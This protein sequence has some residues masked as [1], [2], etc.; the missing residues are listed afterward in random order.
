MRHVSRIRMMASGWTTAILMAGLTFASTAE[1]TT[2]YSFGGFTLAPSTTTANTTASNFSFT[3]AFGVTQCWAFAYPDVACGGFGSAIGEFT[4]A[5]LA[6]YRLAI[7]GLSFDERNAGGAG[8]TAFH[9][10]TSADGFTSPIIS[11]ALAQGAPVFTNHAVSLSL[12]NLADPFVVRIAATGRDGLPMSSWF[13]DNVTL[14]VEAV[15]I[16]TAVPEP[17]TL[18]LLGTGIGFVTTRRRRRSTV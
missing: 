1:A 3:S 4:V 2:I 8:P 11:G 14:N 6:G 5:P 13:L 9:V 15:P 17:T 16:A 10:L 18:L 7:T 12:F